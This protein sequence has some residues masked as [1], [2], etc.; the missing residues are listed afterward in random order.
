VDTRAG[1]RVDTRARTHACAPTEARR[2]RRRLAPHP[3]APPLR[4]PPKKGLP[5]RAVEV[6][7]HLRSGAAGDASHLLD[8]YTYTTAI[9]V[10]SSSQQLQRA[11]ELAAEMRGR[12]I[13]CNV[14]TYS[15]LMNVCIKSNEVQLAQEVYKQVRRRGPPRTRAR[16]SIRTRCCRRA[17][18]R[19]SPARPPTAPTRPR[20]RCSRTG[21]PPT[22][23][24]STP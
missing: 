21:A 6:F 17:R 4:L 18:C 12:G 22:W 19:R 13:S 11:L 7:D 8:I 2:A 3:A 20:A 5:M 14:H 1:R 24:P 23:S 9:S 16:A 10:C 15:A